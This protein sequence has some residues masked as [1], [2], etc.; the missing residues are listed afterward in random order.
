MSDVLRSIVAALREELTKHRNKPFLEAAMAVSAYV[1]MADGAV[2]FSERSRLDAILETLDALR[3]Y[4][5]HDAVDLFDGLTDEFREDSVAAQCSV[6]ETL[7]AFADQPDQA[8]LLIR[9]ALAIAHADGA[10]SPAE[11][12]RLTELCAILD[13]APDEALI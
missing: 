3:I 6:L 13:I 7:R 12:G 5:P 9:I 11:Q 4:D 8:R 10:Y 2:T 1:A